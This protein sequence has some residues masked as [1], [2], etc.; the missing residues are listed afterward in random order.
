M[1][2]LCVKLAERPVQNTPNLAF[3]ISCFTFGI[4]KASGDTF[5]HPPQRDGNVLIFCGAEKFKSRKQS[6]C[7]P[8]HLQNQGVLTPTYLGPFFTS[9]TPRKMAALTRF[10]SA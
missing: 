9:A 8:Q 6:A 1:F 10:A 2:A 3:Q 5:P 4:V 7:H